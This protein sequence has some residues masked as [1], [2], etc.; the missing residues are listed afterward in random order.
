M[1]TT[2]KHFVGYGA[3][4]GGRDYNAAWIPTSQLFDLHLPPFKAAFDAGAMTAMAAFNTLNGVPATAHRGMLTDLLRG[5]WGFRG[6]VTSDFGS[7]PELKAAVAA[8]PA[9]TRIIAVAG[10]GHDL[11][12][13]RIDFAEAVAALLAPVS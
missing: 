13:G 11:K 2:A 1:A 10:A 8:I 4:E 12:R 5:K 7:I 9:P 6:F 3:V